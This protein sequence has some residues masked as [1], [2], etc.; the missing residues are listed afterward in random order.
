MIA[1]A[2]KVTLNNHSDISSNPGT[3]CLR[4]LFVNS[5][6]AQIRRLLQS[7]NRQYG[8]KLSTPSGQVRPQIL[9][10]SS[11]ICT[12][13]LSARCEYYDQG[14]SSYTHAHTHHLTMMRIVCR[15][16]HRV[17]LVLIAGSTMLTFVFQ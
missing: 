7:P 14:S 3:P 13:F 10:I 1:L 5:S 6:V 8:A 12:E 9:F 2:S 11:D 4:R 15:Y 16:V 17:Y